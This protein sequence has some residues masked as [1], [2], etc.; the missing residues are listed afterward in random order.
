M[1]NISDNSDF[2]IPYNNHDAQ[3]NTNGIS[4]K[5]QIAKVIGFKM[6]VAKLALTHRYNQNKKN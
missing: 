6:A 3:C 5:H 4:T 1:S 2:V